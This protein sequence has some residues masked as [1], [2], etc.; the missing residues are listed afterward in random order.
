MG[1]DDSDV[2]SCVWIYDYDWGICGGCFGD[3]AG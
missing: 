2:D 3:D 1:L